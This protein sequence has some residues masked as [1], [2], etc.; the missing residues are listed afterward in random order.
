ME[1]DLGVLVAVRLRDGESAAGEAGRAV[2]AVRVSPS[3]TLT[4]LRAA[5]AAELDGVP[6]VFAFVDDHGRTVD[7]TSVR[8]ACGARAPPGGREIA[9]S[10][11]IA[12][13]V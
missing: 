2:G 11:I 1:V 4:V 7:A 6:P 8:R 12:L 3:G 10:R 5:V 9:Q 13:F